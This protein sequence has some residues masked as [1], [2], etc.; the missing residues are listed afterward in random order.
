MRFMQLGGI[1]YGYDHSYPAFQAVGLL[2]AGEWP[3]IGQPSSVFVDNPVL[4]A[5]LQTLPLLL[6]RNPIAVQ[7]FILIFNSAAVWFVWRVATDMIGRRA[8]W[9]AALLFAVNPWVVHYSRTTWVQ[10]LVPF[11]MAV[12]AWGIWPSLV[13]EHPAPRRFFIG[14]LAVTLM[15][16]TYVQAWGI[17]PQIGLLVL[18]FRPHVPRRAFFAALAIFVTAALGYALALVGNLESNVAKA[19]NFIDAGQRTLSTIGLRHA[20]RFVNGID[21][22]T[23]YAAD[24]PA[25]AVWPALSLAAVVLASA[26]LGAGII[27]AVSSLRRQGRDR[28]IAI[29]LLTWFFVPVL[30]TSLVDDTLIHPH[31]LM[32]TLPAGSLLAAWGIAPMLRGKAAALVVMALG[33][34][35]LTFAHDLYRAN[36]VVARYPTLPEFSGWSLDAGAELG[37]TMRQALLDTP[38]PYPRRIVADGAKELLSGMSATYV[39]P[40]NSVRFPD[41]VVAAADE[42]LLYLLEEGVEVPTWLE[43]LFDSDTTRSLDFKDGKQVSVVTTL[44]GRAVRFAEQ[45]AVT[46]E[47]PSDTGLTLTGYT[48]RGAAVTGGTLDIITYWRVDEIDRARNEW[49]VA[50]S[51]HLRDETGTLLANVGENGQWAYRWVSGDVYVEHISIPVPPTAPESGLSLEIALFDSVHV[52]PHHFMIGGA[53]VPSYVIHIDDAAYQQ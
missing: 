10:S 11:C 16:Q 17:L 41:F 29:I 25:G 38:G 6:A 22:R 50:S 33:F 13:E 35:G 20:V 2:D 24:H 51:Y 3:L 40:I 49:Y 21:F 28:R 4:M 12:I 1:R 8:G 15:S 32:L 18:L 37:R 47:W 30:I 53:A 39:A 19:F 26:A 5:Y 42:P 27:K 9:V 36:E 48:F 44:P 34:L 14:G 46:V 31:Y 23:T 7:A 52:T 43:P 45:A